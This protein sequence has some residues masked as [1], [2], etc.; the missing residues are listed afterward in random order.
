[1]EFL[2]NLFNSFL[3]SRKKG[4]DQQFIRGIYKIL[5]QRATTMKV[6]AGIPRVSGTSASRPAQV[7]DTMGD[8]LFAAHSNKKN[9]IKTG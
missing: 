6:S 9:M 8:R 2:G 4:E 7:K 3:S 1:M 5:S